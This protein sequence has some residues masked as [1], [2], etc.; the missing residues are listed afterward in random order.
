[1]NEDNNQLSPDLTQEERQRLRLELQLN[2]AATA[3]RFS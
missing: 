2:E 3:E 1:M